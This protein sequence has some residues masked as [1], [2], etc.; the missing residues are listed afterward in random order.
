MSLQRLRYALFPYTT[1]FR[2]ES[3]T[4]IAVGGAD[5]AAT[6]GLTDAELDQMTAGLLKVGDANSGNMNISGAI[7]PD[8]TSTCLISSHTVITYAG[9]CVNNE[10]NLAVRAAG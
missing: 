2:S 8:N 5:G 1:L 9:V 10:A 6:L 7:N 3:G 4:A